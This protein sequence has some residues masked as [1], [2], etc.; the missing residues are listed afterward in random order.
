[1]ASRVLAKEDIILLGLGLGRLA[2]LRLGRGQLA[3]VD[4]VGALERVQ[5]RCTV[6]GFDYGVEAPS[7][8][9]PTVKELQRQYT[10]PHTTSQRWL[11]M[12]GGRRQR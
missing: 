8:A 1:M 11:E 9:R 7:Y 4:Q 6:P 2:L 3:D 5:E 10:T 12:L